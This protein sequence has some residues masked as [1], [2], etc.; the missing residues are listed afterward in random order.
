MYR[1]PHKILK[2]GVINEVDVYFLHSAP[3]QHIL[4]HKQYLYDNLPIP[5]PYIAAPKKMEENLGKDQMKIGGC[6]PDLLD[7]L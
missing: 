5:N 2:K 6:S 4:M 3:A 7:Q 1:E